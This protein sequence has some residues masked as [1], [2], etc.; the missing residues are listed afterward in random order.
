MGI[1]TAAPINAPGSQAN[2]LS[3]QNTSGTILGASASD[4]I[5]FYGVPAVPQRTSGAQAAIA[6]AAQGEVVT[7][8][9]TLSP[10]ACNAN[11]TAEQLFTCNGLTA[12]SLVMVNKPTAQAGLGIAN[13]RVS[14]ANQIGIT[15]SNNTGGAV[16]PTGGEVYQITEVKAA[17]GITF[18]QA[19]TPTAVPANSVSEQTF[20]IAGA[21]ANIISPT[22]GL[23]VNKP[24]NQ[25][26]LGIGNVRNIGSANQV[27]IT[28]FN[29]TAAPI[30]PTA[31]ESYLFM[32]SNGLGAISNVVEYG[33]NVGTLAAVNTVTAPELAIA[34]TG[35][36]TTDVVMGVSK[37]TAQAGLGIAGY[38]VAGANSL[39]VTFV[40][41]T[42]GNITPT[43]S[44]I[45]NVSVFRQAPAAPLVGYYQAL[46]PVAVAANTTAEQTFTV[47][48]LVASSQVA[49]NKPTVTTGLA[50]VGAR[51]SAANTLAI[52]YQNVTAS[53]I[54]PPAETYGIGNWQQIGPAGSA[55][56]YTP[57]VAQVAG[58]GINGSTNLTN[59]LRTALVNLGLIK[60]S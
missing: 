17:A 21:G 4:L 9:L 12:G 11:T 39:G 15:F 41:P 45:Y 7:Y 49:V 18:S 46:T 31:A 8:Q 22:S 13:V 48:G 28:F 14:A 29:N 37:P 6:P 59:E 30:T 56:T 60:G 19:L 40:N 50:I 38:R 58:G 5:G 16:T 44:E 26:G 47:T 33:I 32:A 2:Q 51:V 23:I 34:M 52:T 53:P 1:V 57:Y 24:A 10:A 20:T 55:S 25:A 36:L 42:A 3:D 35:L 54:T 43:G 27:A